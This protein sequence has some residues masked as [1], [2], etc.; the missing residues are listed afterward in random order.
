EIGGDQRLAD[1]FRAAVFAGYK[2][3][4]GGDAAETI[5][6]RPRA[7]AQIEEIGVGIEKAPAI[8]RPVLPEHQYQAVRVLVRKGPQEH[9]V[10]HAEDRRAG[11]DAQGEGDGSS[12]RKNWTLAQNSARVCEVSNEIVAHVAGGLGYRAS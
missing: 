7:G 12:G 3:A 8:R 1:L 5:E 9:G 6:D 2:R 11:A 4:E 10:G